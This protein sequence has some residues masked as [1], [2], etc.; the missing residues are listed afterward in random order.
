MRRHSPYNYAFNNPVFFIDPDGMAP[1]PPQDGRLYDNGYVHT[2]SDG[3]WVYNADENTWVGLNG[4]D[5]FINETVNLNEATISGTKDGG[6]VATALRAYKNSY[7]GP[8]FSPYNPDAASLNFGVSGNGIFAHFNFSVSVILTPG[9]IAF[10]GTAD[11]GIGFSG[12]NPS[13][14]PYASVGFHDT[15]G[16]ETN[17]L[18]G[19]Q[20]PSF[21]TNTTLGLI[22]LNYSQSAIRTG[23]YNL[24]GGT[25]SMSIGI[26][27]PGL[28]ISQTVSDT[29]V[30]RPF[31]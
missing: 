12:F 18:E 10:S 15:Y 20:G 22:N 5:T 16:S 8:Q 17:V 13:F 11:A 26:G 7:S 21:N 4:E 6:L 25:R 1:E 24:D 2:D 27:K 30:W 28:G 9:E 19:M 3:S 14:G 31:R 29:G 23:K